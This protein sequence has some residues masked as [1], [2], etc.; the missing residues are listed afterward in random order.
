MSEENK[1]RL[2]VASRT[3]EASAPAASGDTPAENLPPPTRR[4]EPVRESASS[5]YL[6]LIPPVL[7]TVALVAGGWWFVREQSANEARLASLK[8]QTAAIRSDADKLRNDAADMKRTIDLTRREIEKLNRE[9]AREALD[10]ANQ[11]LRDLEST[12]NSTASAAERKLAEIARTAQSSVR[13]DTS[14]ADAA[15]REANRELEKLTRSRD[16]LLAEVES[17]KAW[18]KTHNRTMHRS[19]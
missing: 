11:A 14:A 7:V 18:L 6:G 16:A 19:F 15:L 5:S 10:K 17:M 1:P 9:R 12:L 8:S 3:Q 2:K 13:V 4:I